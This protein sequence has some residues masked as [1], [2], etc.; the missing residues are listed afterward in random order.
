MYA[1]WGGA[2]AADMLEWYRKEYGFE[3]QQR[4]QKEGGVDWDY[5]VAEA[6]AAPAGAH[7][8]MFLPHMSTAG[9]PVVDAHSMGAFVGLSNFVTKGDLLRA[10]I[11][12]LD[13]QFLDIVNVMG[14]GLGIRPDKFVV[15]GGAVRN[16]FWMQNKADVIGM[17]IEVPEAEEATPLGAAILAGIGVGLYQNE[18]DAFQRVYRP[19]KTYEPDLSLASKYADWFQVYKQLYPTLKPISHQLYDRFF[20]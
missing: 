19:G 5:L 15:V 9:C 14:A 7:G 17:P 13:Y 8:A 16:R 12:G 1:A 3:A 18:Q 10:I 11:E 6:A 2:V 20:A 4:A